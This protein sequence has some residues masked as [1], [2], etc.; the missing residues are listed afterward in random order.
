MTPAAAIRSGVGAAR[1]RLT[2][3]R[4]P[5]TVHLSVT[6]RCNALCS[7]CA[8]PMSKTPELATPELV[9]LIDALAARGTVRVAFSGG[10][11][12]LRD[13]MGILVDRCADHGIWTALETNGDLYP[14]RADELARLDR[15]IVSLDG[16]E[17]AHDR[18]REPGAWARAMAAIRAASARGIDLH[19]VTVLTRDN[20]DQM[21]TVLDIAERYGFIADFQVLQSRPILHPVQA[22]RLLPTTPATRKAL[23]HLLEARLAGRPVGATEKYL[24]YL[25]TWEDFAQSTSNAPHEDLHCLAGQLYCAI[26]PAGTVTPCPLL[27][28]RYPGRNVHVDGIDSAFESLRDNACRACT[29][30][31][32]TEYNYLYNLNRPAVFER[33]RSF[34]HAG[35]PR[36]GAP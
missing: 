33:L 12:L 17:A 35:P 24:R 2:G 31:A 18:G 16:G 3:R 34:R 28:G 29:S 10:E 22:A 25:L 20:L 19:T 6:N 5:L 1:Y 9:A 14:G 27:A 21:D 4:M 8:V 7:Y 15:L 26:D 32:L 11:P 30:T 36:K 13:D 23:L